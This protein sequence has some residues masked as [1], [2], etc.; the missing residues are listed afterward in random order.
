MGADHTT[1]QN[2]NLLENL[3]LLRGL[4][5]DAL[6]TIAREV[7]HCTYTDG[8][9]VNVQP[10]AF[11][12]VVGGGVEVTA[13]NG[14]PRTYEALEFFGQSALVDNA[15]ANSVVAKGDTSLMVVAHTIFFS[16]LEKH[17]SFRGEIMA[18]IKKLK[19]LHIVRQGDADDELL[20]C[21]AG[22]EHVLNSWQKQYPANTLINLVCIFGKMRQGKSYLMNLLHRSEAELTTLLATLERKKEGGN[23]GGAAAADTAGAGAGDA[24]KPSSHFAVAHQL[25]SLTRGVDLS[26][27]VLELTAWSSSQNAILQN[28]SGGNAESEAMMLVG[29]MDAEGQGEEGDE[30]DIRLITPALMV[31]K[32]VLL[33]WQGA[34]QET[35]LTI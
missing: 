35:F 11:F 20:S 8:Q 10:S 27:R 22:V 16:W 21:G 17:P 24:R 29:H 1:I 19:A 34:P 28:G 6:A 9:N 32:A 2:F 30:Y 13:A 33:N 26:N 4:S 3:P 7:E 25:D 18:N 15:R 31:S 12:I 23:V 5:I 14:S